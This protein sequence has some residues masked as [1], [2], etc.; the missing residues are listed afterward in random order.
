MDIPSHNVYNFSNCL[1]WQVYKAIVKMKKIKDLLIGIKEGQKSFGEDIA[2]IIN[3]LLLSLAYLF[4]IGI[5]SMIAKI[6]SKSFLDLKID[7]NAKTYWQELNLGK[8]P[9][10]EY[11][12][13]F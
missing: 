5:T 10:K 8:K 7:K 11:Y 4:G 9:I 6:I 3:F 12:R 1:N 13:Q 2:I